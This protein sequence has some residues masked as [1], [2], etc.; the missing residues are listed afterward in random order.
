[1]WIL[2]FDLVI[3]DS[4]LGMDES[5]RQLLRKKQ[6]CFRRRKRRYW[7]GIRIAIM[8]IY[9]QENGG[10]SGLRGGERDKMIVSFA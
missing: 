7:D 4:G 6:Y 10:N 1:M 3:E 2:T 8:Q 9:D 5:T